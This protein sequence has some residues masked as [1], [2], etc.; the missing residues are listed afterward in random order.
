MTATLD[1]LWLSCQQRLVAH[2]AHDL[3]GALNGASVNVEVVRGRSERP[4]T[5][6]TEV[7]QYAAAAG[8]QLAI[9]IRMT[10]A[11]LTVARPIRGPVDVGTIARNLGALIDETFRVAGLKLEVTVEGGFSGPTSAPASA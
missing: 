10:T 6:I 2:I 5:G 8:D 7:A 4:E 11:L 1:E 3:K 9:V